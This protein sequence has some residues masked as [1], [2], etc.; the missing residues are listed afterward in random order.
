MT[1]RHAS[2]IL[3]TLISATLIGLV[4]CLLIMH[5]REI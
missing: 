1:P 5:I 2:L 4:A 3:T